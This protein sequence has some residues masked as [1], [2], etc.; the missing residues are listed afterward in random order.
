MM[1][2][3]KMELRKFLH[4][5]SKGSLASFTYIGHGNAKDIRVG[6][7]K[8]DQALGI[9]RLL[10][11][12]HDGEIKNEDALYNREL[13]GNTKFAIALQH[14]SRAG[15]LYSFFSCKTGQSF[16]P[17]LAYSANQKNVKA[18]L[19]GA[20]W[21]I[22][23]SQGKVVS[24]NSSRA[25][26]GLNAGEH[27]CLKPWDSKSNQEDNLFRE[28]PAQK[29]G[30]STRLEDKLRLV[31]LANQWL[32]ETEIGK[33]NGVFNPAGLRAMLHNEQDIIQVAYE[34]W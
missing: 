5:I 27:Y 23:N 18:S 25:L 20:H 33:K 24:R 22:V 29:T 26:R 17:L 31:I 21:V 16:A 14:A 19:T 3:G 1:A 15:T 34:R 7:K 13:F 6:A 30:V 2:P 8:I 12:I 10:T 4:S 11:E 28:I 32:V 9:K